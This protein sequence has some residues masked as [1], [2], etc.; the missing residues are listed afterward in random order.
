MRSIG[1]EFPIAPRELAAMT[2][3]TYDRRPGTTEPLVPYPADEASRVIRL[4]PRLGEHE[5]GRLTALACARTLAAEAGADASDE[6]YVLAVASGLCGVAAEL[7]KPLA[8]AGALTMTTLR[9]V[10]ELRAKA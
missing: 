9:E 5:L 4:D 2:D 10:A 6:G 8:T 7:V 1:G 3:H